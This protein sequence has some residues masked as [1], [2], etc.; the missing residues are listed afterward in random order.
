M[1][2]KPAYESTIL[3]QVTGE[4]IRPG[5][6]VLTEK[7][8]AACGFGV[9]DRV[10][11]LGC[12]CGATAWL[13]RSAHGLRSVGLDASALLLGEGRGLHDDLPLVR[14]GAERLPF[15][16]CC[17]SGVFCECLL[18]LFDD[19]RPVLAECWRVLG[20]GGYLAVTDLYLREPG[21]L[22][23]SGGAGG[24]CVFGARGRE[25][26]L[27]LIRESGF[28]VFLWEDHSGYL[29]EL[30]ARLVFAGCSLSE[31]WPGRCAGGGAGIQASVGQARPGYYLLLARKVGGS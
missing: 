18:S 19:P 10:L 11:D 13:M 12:G 29:K 14:G 27:D 6:L 2:R 8:L 30:A 3:R 16:D 22:V 21:F 7:A 26:G 5:G 28:E 4:T 31:F 1:T 23:G 17:F 20:F 24:C 25:D 15:G 9:Q